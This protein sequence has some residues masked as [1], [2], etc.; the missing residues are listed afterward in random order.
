MTWQAVTIAYLFGNNT[1]STQK[2]RRITPNNQKGREG[3]GADLQIE[4]RAIADFFVCTFRVIAL[5][6]ETWTKKNPD[7][8]A[9]LRIAA[10]DKNGS[11][12][13]PNLICL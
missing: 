4:S 8:G 3:Q 11:E 2:M 13:N 5:F 6:F 7:T 12:H 10:L 9:D 1:L